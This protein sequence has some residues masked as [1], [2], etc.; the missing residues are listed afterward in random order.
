[1]LR[2]V[3][4]VP[5]FEALKGFSASGWAGPC[6]DFRIS[7]PNVAAWKIV[8]VSTRGAVATRGL[9]AARGVGATRGDGAKAPWA[10]F[11]RCL[12]DRM[13]SY[14][15]PAGSRLVRASARTFLGPIRGRLKNRVL[16]GL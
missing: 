4:T 13:W 6:A 14:G 3:V 11:G 5:G 10:L 16:E 8:P 9:V 15:H 1:V 12:T 2:H 7:G